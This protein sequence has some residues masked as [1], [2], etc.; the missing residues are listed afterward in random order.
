MREGRQTLV[1]AFKLWVAAFFFL[2]VAASS[3]AGG[4]KETARAPRMRAHRLAAL[5]PAHSGSR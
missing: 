4:L 2:V 3:P 1:H 5:S